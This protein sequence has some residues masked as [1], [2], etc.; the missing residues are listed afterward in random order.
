MTQIISFKDDLFL[1]DQ[2]LLSI[3]TVMAGQVLGVGLGNGMRDGVGDRGAGVGDRGAGVGDRGEVCDRCVA[4]D[5]R[6]VRVHG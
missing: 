6:G 4:V 5:G 3:D 1:S 2:L